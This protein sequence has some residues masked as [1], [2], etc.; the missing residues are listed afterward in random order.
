VYFGGCRK[1]KFYGILTN[2][3]KNLRDRFGPSKH[4]KKTLPKRMFK[5]L[6]QLAKHHSFMVKSSAS[7]IFYPA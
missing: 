2:R 3:W 1:A 5:K 4:L 6:Y 7:Q